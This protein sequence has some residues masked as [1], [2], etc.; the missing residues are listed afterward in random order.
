MEG[1]YS[2]FTNAAT[3]VAVLKDGRRQDAR[4]PDESRPVC[5]SLPILLARRRETAGSG[6][7]I[8]VADPKN[9]TLT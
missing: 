8:R 9:H 5:T 1:S 7:Q 3:D 2:P 4:F 6:V